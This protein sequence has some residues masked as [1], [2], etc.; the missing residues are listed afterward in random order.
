MHIRIECSSYI[1]NRSPNSLKLYQICHFLL[2]VNSGELPSFRDASIK[3]NFLNGSCFLNS[4]NY[5]PCCSFFDKGKI[6]YEKI[7]IKRQLTFLNQSS[8]ILNPAPIRA[9]PELMRFDRK[10]PE[11]IRYDWPGWYLNDVNNKKSIIGTK[12]NS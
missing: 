6:S 4:C 8:A 7:G 1:E 2:E 12:F 10:N 11:P 9:N 5:S 3:P